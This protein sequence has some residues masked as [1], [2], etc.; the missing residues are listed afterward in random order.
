MEKV[1]YLLWRP[2]TIDAE[3]WSAQLRGSLPAALREAGALSA[4]LNL[5]DD[6]VA[7]AQNLRQ[8]LLPEQPGAL[9]QV[10]LDSANAPLRAPVDAVVAAHGARHA[11]YLVTE[12]L[13]MRNTRHPA[14]AG[15]RTAGFSQ[16]ALLRR[17]P[18]LTHQQ[19][20][21]H[22]QTV[23]TPVA[24]ETQDTFEYVQNVV[25][26]ALSTD[27]P[28]IDG[29]VEECF[30]S[31]AMTDPLAFFDARGDQEKFQRNL[32]TMMDSVNRFLDLPIDCIPTSQYPLF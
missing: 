25:V 5:D 18:R 28:T 10:W 1:I 11:A 32:Q 8:K 3:S 13:P 15:A 6:A 19:W 17:P 4:R 9:V 20:F 27:A 30:P 2:A 22:W 14:R 23:Q 7:S 16:I 21:Q 29:I 31:D 26:R 12:S 24:I